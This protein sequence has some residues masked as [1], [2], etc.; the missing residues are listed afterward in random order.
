VTAFSRCAQV[1]LHSTSGSRIRSKTASCWSRASSWARIASSDRRWA[2]TACDTA[3][4]WAADIAPGGL[5]SA[6]S[7]SFDGTAPARLRARSVK[8]RSWLT[9]SSMDRATKPLSRPCSGSA[10]HRP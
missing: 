10:M 4:N 8:P 7:D 2:L 6:G 1:A 9:N 5:G 3:R